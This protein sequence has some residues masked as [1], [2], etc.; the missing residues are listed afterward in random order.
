MANPLYR[1]L[2]NSK[3]W[4]ARSRSTAVVLSPERGRSTPT[5][6]GFLLLLTMLVFGPIE[7][8]EE[9][10]DVLNYSSPFRR[11]FFIGN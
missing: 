4:R 9:S 8:I 1:R 10:H 3:Q 2:Y 7:E 6:G 11:A 5:I